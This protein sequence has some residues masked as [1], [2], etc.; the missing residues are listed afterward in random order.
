MSRRVIILCNPQDKYYKKTETAVK[1]TCGC[2]EII[3]SPGKNVLKNLLEFF[4]SD[5]I[6]T[7]PGHKKFFVNRL[8]LML[9]DIFFKPV[10]SA[11][12]LLPIQQYSPPVKQAQVIIETT[13]KKDRQWMTAS[14]IFHMFDEEELLAETQ[15]RRLRMKGD[16]NG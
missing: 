4:K 2:D 15:S 8:Q 13:P 12:D 16:Y 1:E 14:C 3:S 10:I 9:A 5:L 6:V 11:K 7:M